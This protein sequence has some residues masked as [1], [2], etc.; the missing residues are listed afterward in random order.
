[1]DLTTRLRVVKFGLELGGTPLSNRAVAMVPVMARDR[2]SASMQKQ[3]QV[4]LS[5]GLSIRKVAHALGVSRQTVRKFG[6]E[7]TVEREALPPAHQTPTW[8]SAIDWQ[9]VGEDV[10]RGATI[11]QL[12]QET[13]PE[14]S[15][16][17]FRRRLLSKV[18]KQ[19]AATIRLEHKPAEQVQIDYCD[20]VPI[21]DATT[22][23]STK[24]HLFC[25]VLPFSSYAFGEFV[26]NQSLPSF[27]GSHERMWAFFGGVT[28]YVVVDNLKA[29]VRN[30]HRYDPDVNPTYCEY[31]NHQG[32]AVLPARPYKPRDKATVEATIGAIQRGFFQEVRNRKFYSLADLNEAFRKYLRRFNSDIMKDHGQSRDERFAY[33]QT[34]LKPLPAARFELFEWRSAKVHP[35]CHVQI[36]KCFYSVPHRTIGQTVRVRISDKLVELFTDDHEPLAA[37]TRQRGIG[38]FST[39][40]LHYPDGKVSIKRFEVR[41]AQAEA[42]RIGPKT[43]ALVLSL[44]HCSHPLRHLRRVQGILRLHQGGRFTREALEYAAEMAV[45]FN[46][47]RL[48]YIQACAEHYN[49]NGARLVLL[50]PTRNADDLYLH[51]DAASSLTSGG[52]A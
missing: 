4:L 5:Q 3:I 42:E 50:R 24:T 15:Y 29:G 13:A 38:K 11:K 9:T 28:P 48:A 32:F 20:G 39:D 34:L 23:I 1:V 40:E 46:K 43:A 44:I 49:V 30:A 37:H 26:F 35:D 21:V 8:D 19:A 6:A 47:P 10:A 51:S 16:T 22:G 33:E 14:V 36:D 18:P 52:E 31:G 27:I 41:S 17:R 7:A 25:G 12:H 45:T 2:K